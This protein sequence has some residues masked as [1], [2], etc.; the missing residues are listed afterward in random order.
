MK[1]FTFLL[2]LVAAAAGGF[3]YYQNYYI[4]QTPSK[5]D[6][7]AQAQVLEAKIASSSETSSNEILERLQIE[8]RAKFPDS[9][10]SIQ[11]KWAQTQYENKL[12]IDKLPLPKGMSEPEFAR[13]KDTFDTSMPLRYNEQYSALRDQIKAY[14]DI[15]RIEGIRNI[16]KKDFDFAK[17]K[18]ALMYP[19]NFVQQRNYLESYAESSLKINSQKEI[20]SAEDFSRLKLQAYNLY[21]D[22]PLEASTY[23]L[24]QANAKFVIDSQYAADTYRARVAMARMQYPNDYAA[25]YDFLRAS[26]SLGVSNLQNIKD[27]K[28]ASG[29]A[30]DFQHIF[31]L[32]TIAGKRPAILTNLGGKPVFITAHTVLNAGESIVLE[33]EIE[34]IKCSKIVYSKN[35]PI[36]LLQP[37]T[38]PKTKGAVFITEEE[39]LT[40]DKLPV[41]AVGFAPDGTLAAD[42]VI[43]MLTK[44]KFIYLEH[45]LK[46]FRNDCVL[47]D[48]ATGRYISISVSYPRVPY[49]HPTEIETDTLKFLMSEENKSPTAMCIKFEHCEKRF[50]ES[51]FEGVTSF[52][53]PKDLTTWMKWDDK[54]YNEQCKI[55]EEI[56][57]RNLSFIKCF[58]NYKASNMSSSPLIYE[59]WNKAQKITN[60][61]KSGK[62]SAIS[63][64]NNLIALLE[65]DI[66]KYPENYFYP[67]LSKEAAH[68]IELRKII[69]DTLAEIKKSN[70]YS[71]LLPSDD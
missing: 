61:R 10:A 70:E 15:E 60:S 4:K 42:A 18:S 52:A 11:E 22:N 33:N 48:K 20:L 17:Q 58:A 36:A 47:I 53:K 21:P 24:K 69:L 50:R 31:T 25:Q 71:R 63:Y 44:E 12:L 19:S 35:Y 7:M 2:L 37:D 54:V 9:S 1:I 26:T 67:I 66:K 32:N 41:L 34:K 14:L 28:N 51:Q 3:Y 40:I 8:A 38:T 6:D 45:P 27:L 64:G 39:L 29:E 65:Q 68:Q 56:T 16:D 23:F 49:M 30:I 57:S 62:S 46:T 55:L 5:A 59:I 13:L 43:P